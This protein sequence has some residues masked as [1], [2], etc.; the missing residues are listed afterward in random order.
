MWPFPSK[1]AMKD[2]T[3]F[4]V[5]ITRRFGDQG[6]RRR[7]MRRCLREGHGVHIVHFVSLSVLNDH[8]A[9]AAY[10]EGPRPADL[11]PETCLVYCPR[12]GHRIGFEAHFAH[13]RGHL[14]VDPTTGQPFAE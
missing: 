6:E 1:P 4:K 10:C 5:K 2:P 7:R 12:C 11:Q 8:I 14:G 3:G 13:P 9:Q